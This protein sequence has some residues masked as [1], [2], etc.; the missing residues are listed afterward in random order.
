MA[1]E[2][3]ENAAKVSST[4]KDRMFRRF[5]PISVEGT[6]GA[7]MLGNPDLPTIVTLSYKQASG[8]YEVVKVTHRC[9]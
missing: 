6:Q 8:V 4:D 1:E 7:V 3:A 5:L 2:L 9:D